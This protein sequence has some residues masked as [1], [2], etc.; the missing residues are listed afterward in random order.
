MI[1]L[2]WY[3]AY[4]IVGLEWRNTCMH[5]YALDIAF[6]AISYIAKWRVCL[7]PTMQQ[8]TKKIQS[9][10]AVCPEL[11]KRNFNV[12]WGVVAGREKKD[13][14]DVGILWH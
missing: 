7:Y 2:P 10:R 3:T 11:E 12:D 6:F 13:E 14:K 4:I 5:F 8:E 1:M 9:K